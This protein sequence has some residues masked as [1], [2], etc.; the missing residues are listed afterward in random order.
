VIV[1]KGFC[2]SHSQAR[3]YFAPDSQRSRPHRPFALST[4]TNG[5]ATPRR[6]SVPRED[7]GRPL[8][9]S[10]QP[11]G[12]YFW[13]LWRRGRDGFEA[14]DFSDHCNIRPNTLM[15]IEDTNWNIFGRFTP[16]EL[17]N[18]FVEWGERGFWN[19]DV[20]LKSFLFTLK[21][22]HNIAARRFPLRVETK[23]RATCCRHF[24]EPCSGDILVGRDCDTDAHSYARLG[25]RTR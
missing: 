2:D 8:Q 13:L 14:D 18:Q 12:K 4:G 19:A 5:C 23:D 1:K 9:I 24:T 25:R 6:N 22:L 16:T 15:L 17:L 7:Q 21:N 20:S 10:L 3:E 11:A